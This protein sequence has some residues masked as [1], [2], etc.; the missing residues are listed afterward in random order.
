MATVRAIVA[1]AWIAFWVYWLLA[2]VVAKRGTGGVPRTPVGAVIVLLV[3][4]PFLV[5]TDALEVHFP[6]LAAVGAAI[7]LAGLGFAVWARV[8]LGRNWGMPMTQKDEPELITSGPYTLVR[9]PIYTGLLTAI[10]GTAL[11]INLSALLVAAVLILYFWRAATVEER[12]LG[13][14]FPR[15]YPTYRARTKMLIPFVL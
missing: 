10:V 13:A 15:A 7:V 9:H 5:D 14:T 11:A 6:P 4:I 2:A 8:H 3:L 12:N 1:V